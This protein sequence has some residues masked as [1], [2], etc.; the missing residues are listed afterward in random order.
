LWYINITELK[1][2][3]RARAQIAKQWKG[4]ATQITRTAQQH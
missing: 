1:G 2:K 3:G 4:K